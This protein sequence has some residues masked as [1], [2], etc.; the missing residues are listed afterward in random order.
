MIVGDATFPTRWMELSHR[1]DP[2]PGRHGVTPFSC[3]IETKDVLDG[4]IETSHSKEK[5]SVRR[6][7]T[8]VGRHGQPT[9]HDRF[10]KV[11]GTRLAACR[12]HRE[13]RNKLYS[14][15]DP[16]ALPHVRDLLGRRTT[17]GLAISVDFRKMHSQ[18]LEKEIDQCMFRASRRS[19]FGIAPWWHLGGPRRRILNQQLSDALPPRKGGL[20][21]HI[22]VREGGTSR[23]STTQH[24]AAFTKDTIGET[25]RCQAMFFD[26]DVRTRV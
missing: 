14:C 17:D 12:G 24:N 8:Q 7:P 6:E 5:V 15:G 23:A 19:Y 21:C 4:S 2:V 16:D 22:G 9:K 11:V 18:A 13:R 1:P 25:K 26:C 10:R 20:Q 3:T